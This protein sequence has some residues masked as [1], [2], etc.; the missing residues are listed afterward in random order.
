MPSLPVL[1]GPS[2]APA[3]GGE[4]R[5]IVILLHGYGSNGADLLKGGEGDDFDVECGAIEH[6]PYLPITEQTV[7][8]RAFECS[9]KDQ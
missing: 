3:S 1:D 9:K 6:A 5:Q 2:L 8:R 7:K 4:A